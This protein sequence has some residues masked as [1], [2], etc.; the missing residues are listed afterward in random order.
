MFIFARIE[1]CTLTLRQTSMRV[2]RAFG[3]RDVDR[4]VS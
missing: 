2:L 4:L 3:D 1:R